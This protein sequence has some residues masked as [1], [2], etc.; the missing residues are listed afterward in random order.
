MFTRFSFFLYAILH[1]PT[2]C[3]MRLPETVRCIFQSLFD[4]PSD[5]CSMHLPVTVR[6]A[7]RFQMRFYTSSHIYT[8]CHYTLEFDRASSGNPGKSGETGNEF[9]NLNLRDL[10]NEA[11]DLK[12]N[13]KS[14]SVQHVPKGSNRE[15]DAQASWGKNLE[16]G[17]VQEDYYYY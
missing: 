2:T 14:G 11:L 7:F 12:D 17:Q 6:C 8:L 9:N 4:A 3:S 16:V 10:R 13:F 5:D 15:V 1:F